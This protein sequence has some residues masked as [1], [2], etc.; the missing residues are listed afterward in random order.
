MLDFPSSPSVGQKFNPGNG[1]IYTWDGVAWNL[2]PVD[3]ATARSR[4]IIVN[5]NMRISQQNAQTIGSA[6]G[7][8]MADQWA[9]STTGISFLCTSTITGSTATPDGSASWINCNAST[10][11]PSLAA[12]DYLYMATYVEGNDVRDLMWGT[13]QAKPA[14]VRFNSKAQ[15][16]GKYSLTIRNAGGDRSFVAA[17]DATTA[18]QTFVIPVPGCVDGTW[19]IDST[20]SMTFGFCYCSGTTY[21]APLAGWNSG[22]YLA[23][24]GQINAAATI[25]QN[26]YISDVGFY[27]DPDNT[28]VPPPWELPDIAYDLQRC[29]R[30][31]QVFPAIIGGGW[32]GAVNMTICHPVSF[33]MM[34]TTPTAGLSTVG[35]TNTTGTAFT[36]SGNTSG[37]MSTKG[38]AV[39]GYICQFDLALNAR[40]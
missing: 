21:V 25:S 19:A 7:Y 22:N 29:F 5:P 15:A 18:W 11:K 28:G 17:F 38:V 3:V 37:Y 32:V 24:P 8:Y 33:P 6:T 34:R 35:N 2:A 1:S 27:E 14:V 16:P 36:L 4:N 30:Y 31:Y 23:A 40:M 10:A 12:G 9:T 20:R 39:G 13:P 26:L